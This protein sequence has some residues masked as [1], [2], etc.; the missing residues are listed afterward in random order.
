MAC[1]E[2]VLDLEDCDECSPSP[3]VRFTSSLGVQFDQER[4]C[5]RCYLAEDKRNGVKLTPEGLCERCAAHVSGD[6]SG[7]TPEV[8]AR[9]FEEER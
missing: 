3:V 4:G 1:W 5:R 9:I 8:M 2:C 7:L 6:Y